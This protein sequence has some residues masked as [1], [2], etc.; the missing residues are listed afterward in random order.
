MRRRTQE[1]NL[2]KIAKQIIVEIENQTELT[3]LKHI[4]QQTY[5]T[6]PVIAFFETI[7]RVFYANEL[8]FNKIFLKTFVC[9]PPFSFP[10][11]TIL[12]HIAYY[13]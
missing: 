3:F 6:C 5:P 9:L 7:L 11:L 13:R 10:A 4:R 12:I 1:L 8:L 2:I